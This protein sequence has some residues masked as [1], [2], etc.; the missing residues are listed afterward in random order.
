MF[1]QVGCDFPF[2]K[3]AIWETCVMIN[4]W[5][6]KTR[7]GE[8]DAAKAI[9][10]CKFLQNRIHFLYTMFFLIYLSVGG[11]RIPHIHIVKLRDWYLGTLAPSF[12][13]VVRDML[14]RRYPPILILICLLTL[15]HTKLRHDVDLRQQLEMTSNSR[16][17]P[18]E[19]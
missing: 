11:P 2:G 15:W 5:W 4:H 14:A 8:D 19:S 17:K 12:T 3:T 10:L 1:Q 16:N 9:C 6:E 7:L 13:M 18:T